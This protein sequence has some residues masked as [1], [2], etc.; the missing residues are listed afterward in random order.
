MRNATARNALAER[1]TLRAIEKEGKGIGTASFADGR[2][3]FVVRGISDY[4]DV[5]VDKVWRR[6]ASAVAAAYVRALLGAC[7]SVDP[8]GG[9]TGGAD[10]R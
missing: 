1:H 3:W 5:R 4:G 8:H 7:Q 9:R 6:Y 10:A 2:E